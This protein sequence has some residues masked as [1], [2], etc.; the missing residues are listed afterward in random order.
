MLRWFGF[1]VLDV[2]GL[3][4]G[5]IVRR[6]HVWGLWL[7]EELTE[8]SSATLQS[9]VLPPAVSPDGGARRPHAIGGFGPVNHEISWTGVRSEGYPRKLQPL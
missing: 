2:L 8:Q 6:E 4:S 7:G 5:R 3:R 1:L 9:D